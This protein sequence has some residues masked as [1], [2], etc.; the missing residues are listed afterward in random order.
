MCCAHGKGCGLAAESEMKQNSSPD[1]RRGIC[2]ALKQDDF[3]VALDSLLGS[4]QNSWCD[5]G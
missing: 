1:K 2:K 3:M 5:L 4:M